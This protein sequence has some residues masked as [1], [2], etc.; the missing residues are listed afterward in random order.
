MK[1]TKRMLVVLLTLAASAVFGL[2]PLGKDQQVLPARKSGSKAAEPKVL[3]KLPLS[4]Q[5]HIRNKVRYYT[6][7]GVSYMK[8]NRD[9]KVVYVEIAQD[10]LDAQ[11]K[12]AASKRALQ[13]EIEDGDFD[14]DDDD[15][16]RGGERSGGRKRSGGGGR[17]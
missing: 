6:V 4:A 13:E 7:D 5:E 9:G 3:V 10:K 1:N 11:I 15:N 17:R 12:A 2:E 8:S 14:D 16:R